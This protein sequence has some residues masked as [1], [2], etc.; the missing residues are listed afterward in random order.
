MVGKY[1]SSTRRCGFVVCKW[2]WQPWH[3]PSKQISSITSEWK[4]VSHEKMRTKSCQD[5]E[6]TYF[7]FYLKRTL[8]RLH[9]DRIFHTMTDSCCEFFIDI[10]AVIFIFFHIHVYTDYKLYIYF[11]RWSCL[12]S[13][14]LQFRTIRNSTV[15]INDQW[16]LL[17]PELLWLLIVNALQLN[18]LSALRNTFYPEYKYLYIYIYI[19][20]YFFHTINYYHNCRFN[21]RSSFE[22]ALVL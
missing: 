2:T 14:V 17:K 22:R 20:I 1:I 16:L 5:L 10:P 18:E 7:E 12:M 4:L 8:V 6:M 13:V 9:V 15:A 19:Y 21:A 3:S 11:N